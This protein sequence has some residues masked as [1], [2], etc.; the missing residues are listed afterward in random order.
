MSTDDGPPWF[1]NVRTRRVEGRSGEKA[2]NRLGPFATREEA[3]DALSRVAARNEAWDEAD[4]RD[5]DDER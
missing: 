1:Y 3:A 4:R 2:A 5:D